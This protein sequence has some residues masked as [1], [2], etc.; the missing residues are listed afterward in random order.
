MPLIRP[1]RLL[2]L[3][4]V[5]LAVPLLL[6]VGRAEAQS[7]GVPVGEPA[8]FTSQLSVLAT[9]QQVPQQDAG[10]RGEPGALGTFDLRINRATE[11]ICHDINL[12]GVTTPFESPAPTAVHI[13]RGARGEAGPPVWLF[14]DPTMAADGTLQSSGCLQRAFPADAAGFSLAELEADPA[15]FY[16]DV[17]TSA[18]PAGAVRGQLGVAAPAGGVAAGG[19]GLTGGFTWLA[20]LSGL[21][22]TAVGGAGVVAGPLRARARG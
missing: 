12:R 21:A 4:T 8:M 17:H 15:A 2:A 22:L 3:A 6:A 5:L 10:G 13:H 20:A 19:G 9:A 16:V 7:T 1:R 14:P 11:T 18:F